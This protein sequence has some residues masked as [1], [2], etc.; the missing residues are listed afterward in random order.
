MKLKSVN[1]VVVAVLAIFIFS[2]ELLFSSKIALKGRYFGEKIREQTYKSLYTIGAPISF[3]SI[4][5]FAIQYTNSI[6]ILIYFLVYFIMASIIFVLFLKIFEPI[7]IFIFIKLI[8]WWKNKGKNIEVK[9]KSYWYYSTLLGLIAVAVYFFISIAFVFIFNLFGASQSIII[10]AGSY[11]SD[12]PTLRNSYRLD[13]LIL[14]T[15]LALVIVPLIIMLLLLSYSFRYCRSM[16]RGFTA[17]LLPI[18]I[19]SI[20]FVIF[21]INPLINFMPD[22]Y[23]VTGKIS[24]TNA[25]GF[26]FYTFRTAAFSANLFPGGQITLLGILAIPYL[27]TRYIFAV[28]IWTL[29]IYYYKRVFKTEN[30]PIDEKN[31]KKTVFSL[32]KEYITYDDY[33]KVSELYL[34]SRNVE[35]IQ[36]NEREEIKNII[37]NLENNK[38]LKDLVPEG[39]NE[40]K[41]FYF[42]LK[43]LY[44]NN[45]ISIWKQEFSFIFEKVEKQGLYMIHNDGR[46]VFDFRFI[47]GHFTDPGLISGMFAAITSFIKET[48]KSADL[49]KTI[50]HGDIT[51]LIEYGKSIFGALFIKGTQTA[52][53]RAQ[54]IEFVRRFES[55]HYDLLPNWSG[56]L[57]PFR[58]DHLLVEEIFKE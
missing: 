58:Q 54:L 30:I 45:L 16:F 37:T 20:I 27:Y 57:E 26:R 6:P 18:I 34:I 48:T 55:K 39:L 52:E 49:L 12:N 23:W 43:Y 13:M 14:F 32:V 15:T 53:I 33:N 31:V 9:K 3:L 51:I 10:N 46:G 17:F 56:I 25:F 36:D 1:F 50:D 8:N 5:L 22:E 4:V 21:G 24:Y 2:I 29:M 7:S 47:E 35:A 38:R 40:K 41:K 11:S 44:S 42:T 28:V 19:I